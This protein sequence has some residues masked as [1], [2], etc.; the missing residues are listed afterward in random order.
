MSSSRSRDRQTQEEEQQKSRLLG[1]GLNEQGMLCLE[2]TRAVTR[3]L[4][5]CH[6]EPSGDSVLGLG[7]PHLRP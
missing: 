2:M 6:G 5:Q 7:G 4:G 1:N 3:G